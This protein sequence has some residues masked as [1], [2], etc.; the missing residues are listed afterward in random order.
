MYRL[1]RR[2]LSRQRKFSQNFLVNRKL[3]QRLIRG[4]SISSKDL[5]LEIGP[6][7]GMIT[8][9]LLEVAREVIAIELDD[10][11]YGQLQHKFGHN[12]KLIAVHS[13]FLT[14]S[15]PPGLYKVFANIPFSIT[16]DVVRK[17]LQSSNPP[18]DAYLVMQS[19]A[20]SKFIVHP[21]SS[22]MAAMHYFPWWNIQIVHRFQRQDFSPQPKVESVLLHIQPRPLPLI[23]IEQIGLYWDFVAYHF[24]HDRFAKFVPA[25]KWLSLFENF[26]HSP[27]KMKTVRGSFIKLQHQ[28]NALERI[29]RTRT[30]KNWRNFKNLLS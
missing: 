18:R 5:V 25:S 8:Q 30:D 4:S 19:E 24:T 15:L 13:D 7:Q 10:Q 20:A 1:Q 3:V 27:Q 23:S 2:L 11:L 21:G 9:E 14:M 28:Q 26:L 22:T 12:D 29:H 17:L 6:G 16:G